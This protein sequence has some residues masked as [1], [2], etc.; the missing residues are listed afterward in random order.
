MAVERDPKPKLS[1]GLDHPS[2]AGRKRRI[3]AKEK[4]DLKLNARHRSDR[5]ETYPIRI[6]IL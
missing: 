4:R 3:N 6:G 1:N 5:K 2:S